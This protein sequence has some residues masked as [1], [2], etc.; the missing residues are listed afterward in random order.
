[1]EFRKLNSIC[2]LI[3]LDSLAERK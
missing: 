1:M 2:L 3:I